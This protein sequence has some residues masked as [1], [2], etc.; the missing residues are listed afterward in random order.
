MDPKKGPRLRRKFLP[1]EILVKEG[2]RSG[3]GY[4]I[5]RGRVRVT[6]KIHG[7]EEVVA[8][9]GANDL[10]GEMSIVDQKP[11]S[12]TVS[13]IVETDALILNLSNNI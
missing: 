6:K 5:L 13:A 4:L 8:E 3:R 12:A 10:V 7:R 2:E 1:G 11:R 9:L